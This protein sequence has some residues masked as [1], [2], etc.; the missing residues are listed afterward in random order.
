MTAEHDDINGLRS[1]LDAGR[2]M[3]LVDADGDT[4]LLV[5]V[6]HN[7]VNTSRLL[8]SRHANYNVTDRNGMTPIQIAEQNGNFQLVRAI[9]AVGAPVSQ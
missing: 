9:E 5:A 6:K 7:A 3:E 8:L 2:D 1:V 4:P